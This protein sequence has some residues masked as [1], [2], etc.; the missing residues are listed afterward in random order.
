MNVIL[1]D[2]VNR[3]NLYPIVLTRPCASI[4]VGMFTIQEKWDLYL[5]ETS[6][7][8]VPEFL[9][10]KYKA[11]F[12]DENLYV[13]A[14]LLPGKDVLDQ[15][16][17]LKP[18]EKLICDGKLVAFK[19]GKVMWEN[20]ANVLNDLSPVESNLETDFIE[21][22]W[23]IIRHLD[24]QLKSDFEIALHKFSAIELPEY[25]TAIHPELIRTG[26]NVKIGA[27][28]LN[29]SEGA[30][31]ID[32]DAEIMDGAMLKGPLYMGKHSVVKMG[33]KIY[34][35]VATGEHC[36]LGGEVTDSVLQAYSNKGHDGFLG[37]SYLGEWCN[38][39][40]DTNTSNLKNNYEAVRLWN[41]SD[42]SFNHTNM[43]FLGAIM[44]DHAKTG[45]NTM[46]N[47]GTVIGVAGNVYGGGFLRNFVPD[48]CTGSPSKLSVFPYRQV[49]K[50][51][52][53]MMKRRNIEL[54]SDEE[55]ILFAAFEESKEYR[56][57]I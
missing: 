40:A 26:T 1:F 10:G 24:N 9:S 8:L 56:K 36:R 32:D 2:P 55:S 20:M 44:G 15:I 37:H 4:R 43:Q 46:L 21:H 25:T 23:D 57:F 51:A 6:T 11:N 48:F 18:G 33:A 5:G 17:L 42:H 47:S 3:K 35:P 7:V 19:Q 34:G 16:L 38:L 50:M 22:T 30:I 31:I 53:A 12:T 13:N 14:T 41:Y 27:C 49:I 39:G 52:H 29:A 45:I 54:S 28:I